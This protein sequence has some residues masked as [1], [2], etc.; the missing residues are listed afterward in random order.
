MPSVLNRHAGLLWKQSI[1]SW[2]LQHGATECTPA[3]G[4]TQLRQEYLDLPWA[5]PKTK[6]Q[7][8]KAVKEA[9]RKT[10]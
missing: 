10:R 8:V 6:H 1:L 3:N 4:A 9:I 5:R 7:A 2:I